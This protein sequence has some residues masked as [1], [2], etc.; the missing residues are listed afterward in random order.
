[1][2]PVIMPSRR[3]LWG[4]SAIDVLAS[5]ECKSRSGKIRNHGVYSKRHRTHCLG[6]RIASLAPFSPIVLSRLPVLPH[7]FFK[8]STAEDVLSK[9]S[10][11]DTRGAHCLRR[12]PNHH[13]I[14]DPKENNHETP[15]AAAET[16]AACGSHR[17]LQHAQ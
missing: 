14:T 12:H 7:R 10:N 1:M 15:G 9:N 4:R 11:R 2:K 16:Q 8:R 13:R 5:N 6:A 17:S 3:K